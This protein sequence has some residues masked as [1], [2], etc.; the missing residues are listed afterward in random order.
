MLSAHGLTHG[1]S[2][3]T[4]LASDPR[5]PQAGKQ[6][7]PL[8]LDPCSRGLQVRACNT[9]SSRQTRFPLAGRV[10]AHTILRPH[11]EGP[12]IDGQ[13]S[14]IQPGLPPEGGRAPSSQGCPRTAVS[15]EI[16]VPCARA[17]SPGQ[18]S[19][20][21]PAPN[22]GTSPLSCA[23]WGHTP[24]G[25]VSPDKHVARGPCGRGDRSHL[26]AARGSP[27]GV[28]ASRGT[29]PTDAHVQ[30]PPLVVS[31]PGSCTEAYIQRLRQVHSG[32]LCCGMGSSTG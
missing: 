3:F 2:A 6:P 31:A 4:S 1:V 11:G 26:R 8:G 23:W 13:S 24:Q 25:C 17:R 30:E 10:R 5:D 15:P 19:S 28:N 22:M 29:I 20:W 9:A 32:G 7:K 16:P 18:F 27:W 21:Q 12:L 14:Q